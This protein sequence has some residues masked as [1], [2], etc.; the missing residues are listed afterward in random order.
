M[1]RKAGQGRKGVG[2]RHETEQRAT[3]ID[4]GVPSSASLLP[5]QSGKMPTADT[6]VPTEVSISTWVTVKTSTVAQEDTTATASPKVT[7]H[8]DSSMPNTEGGHQSA[9]LSS[10]G[11]NTEHPSKPASP[12][13]DFQHTLTQEEV[14]NIVRRCKPPRTPTTTL[15]RTRSVNDAPVNVPQGDASSLQPIRRTNS[16]S[17]HGDGYCDAPTFDLGID[18]DVGHAGALAPAAQTGEANAVVIDED[19]LDPATL[20][21][22]CVAAD[23]GK[24]LAHRP[25]VGS[26]DSCHTPICEEPA[27]GTSS[28][29]GPPVARRQRR[30][31]LPVLECANVN[32]REGGRHYW[33]FNINLRDGRFDVLDSNRKLEHIELMN[34]ASTIAGAVRQLWRMHYPKQSIGHFWIIDIYVPKQLGNNE[35][36]LFA[37]LNVTE[38]NGSLLPN[39]EPKEV[40]N[41]RKKLAYD[42]VTSTHNSAPWRNLL[43]YEKD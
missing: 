1:G 17:Y 32:D 8:R 24:G 10:P 29:L 23:A 11:A 40:V 38:W 6:S 39:Y 12:R 15:P 36:G 14:A 7:T 43:R 35:C 21:E 9:K 34:T 19:E 4:A 20:N 37:L 41:I 3:A 42:W 25:N 28:S 22:G 31:M 27:V 5:T 13:A 18:D 16:Y 33:F 2:S 26:P 30:V